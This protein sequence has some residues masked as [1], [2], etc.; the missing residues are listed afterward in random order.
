MRTPEHVVGSPRRPAGRS[1]CCCGGMLAWLWP[2]GIGG[3]M[4]VGGDVTQFFLGLMGVLSQS[5][6]GQGGCPV[7]N[8]LWGLSGFPA[9]AESQMGVSTLRIVM[10]SWSFSRRARPMSQ[11]WFSTTLWGASGASS[12]ATAGSESRPLGSSYSRRFPSRR[13][14]Y[15]VIH[16]PHPWGYCR[17]ARG[18][19]WPG[20]VIVVA[21]SRRQKDSRPC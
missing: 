10:L 8:D 14:G 11:A 9:S 21:S 15:F 5:R 20:G 12:A 1:A 13:Q 16:M 17:R 2:I 6:C 4:P 7:W 19:P 18:C 3:K